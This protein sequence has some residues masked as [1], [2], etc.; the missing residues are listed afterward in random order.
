MGDRYS[1]TLTPLNT[2]DN[3]AMIKVV[4]ITE[5]FVRTGT[6]QNMKKN[7]IMNFFQKKFFTFFFLP[8]ELL[9]DDFYIGNRHERVTGEAYD[10]FIDEFMT[11]V[12]RRYGQNTLIQFE[13]FGNHNA[14]R[15]LDK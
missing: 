13:D 12:V 8:Q 1:A 5:I 11:A 14:F 10:E 4:F 15:F 9:E 2:I 6:S 3:V 7:L